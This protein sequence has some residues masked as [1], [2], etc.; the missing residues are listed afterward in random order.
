MYTISPSC[1][2]GNHRQCCEICSPSLEPMSFTV[3]NRGVPWALGDV[4]EGDEVTLC[5][6]LGVLRVRDRV[7]S[8]P[9]D[10]I[11][12]LI[13]RER[14]LK[15]ASQD[16]A[17]RALAWL[18]AQW[19]RD[20]S[21]FSAAHRFA[22]AAQ[23]SRLRVHEQNQPDLSWA[24]FSRL[25]GCSESHDSLGNVSGSSSHHRSASRGA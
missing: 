25:S 13:F 20:P 10:L 12:R 2:H 6:R 22:R 15:A 14:A 8:L 24:S 7:V 3:S 21:Q 9:V 17:L 5:P 16:D 19:E 18:Y 4:T 1:H 11:R 23:R